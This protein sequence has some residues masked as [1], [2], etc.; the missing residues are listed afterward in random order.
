MGLFRQKSLDR[1]N[2]PEQLND[3]I[4][5]TTPS[6]WLIL[7]AT[8]IRMTILSNS[9]VYRT[10][11]LMNANFFALGLAFLIFGLF[12]LIF[13]CGFFKTAY[14]FARPFVTYLIAAFLII[15][16]AEALHHIPGLEAL[17]AF[18]TDHIALQVVTLCA[19]IIAYCLITL[20]AYRTACRHFEKIDL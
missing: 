18:G 8:L 3:Y 17:N 10:N 11:A 1:V 13:V 16:L 2:S 15:T 19:G 7:F 12:N 14:K 9:A 20:A 5:V 6:V 4:R